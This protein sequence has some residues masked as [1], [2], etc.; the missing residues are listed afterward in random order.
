MS[1]SNGD[2]VG[3][4]I[5]WPPAYKKGKLGRVALIQL[6]VSES[7]CYLF[8]ISSMSGWCLLYLF[9]FYMV[10]NCIMSALSP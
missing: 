4:D 2:V 9:H 10:D 6:C 7:K 5:E 8:H 3:F 1:L